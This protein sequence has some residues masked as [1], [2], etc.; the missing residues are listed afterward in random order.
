MITINNKEYRNIVEQVEKNKQDIA[1]HYARDRVLADFGIK[2]IGQMTPEEFAPLLTNNTPPPTGAE[3]FGASYAVGESDPYTFYIWTRADIEAGGSHATNY[4][5]D[6]GV[7]AIEGIEG[8][9]GPS[10]VSARLNSQYNIILTDSKGNEIVV[11]GSARGETG[12]TGSTGPANSIVGFTI[13]PNTYKATLTFAD[14]SSA[15]S[16]MSIRGS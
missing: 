4:W 2:I 12:K 13:D 9:E 11:S 14:G 15:T 16:N 8:P 10:I 6:I 1:T 5:L 3:D 7:L